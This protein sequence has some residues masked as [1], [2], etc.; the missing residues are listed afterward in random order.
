MIVTTGALD[1]GL[2]RMELTWISR[3]FVTIGQPNVGLVKLKF[4]TIGAQRGA[5]QNEECYN[6]H[7]RGA[8]QYEDCDNWHPTCEAVAGR[9]YSDLL[10]DC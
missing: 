7:P 8:G 2:L 3:K 6:W 5:G 4:V 9:T 1:V 10:E